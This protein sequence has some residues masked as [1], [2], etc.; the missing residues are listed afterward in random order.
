MTERDRFERDL[1]RF[2]GDLSRWPDGKRQAAERLLAADPAARRAQTEMARA[3]AAYADATSPAGM[4][5]IDAAAIV[6][7][8]RREAAA[9]ADRLPVPGL[10]PLAA[11]LSAGALA[12]VAASV[13]LF[14]LGGRHPLLQLI[15]ISVTGGLAG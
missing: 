15:E 6:A 8:A 2:G 4:P 5:A 9:A 10:A 11:L 7:R 14:V 1:L 13:A 3:T 12:G